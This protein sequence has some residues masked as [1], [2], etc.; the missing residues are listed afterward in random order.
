MKQQAM[1]E[2]KIKEKYQEFKK[3]S[4]SIINLGDSSES[5][6]RAGGD[7]GSFKIDSLINQNRQPELYFRV[8][9]EKSEVYDIITL[10]MGR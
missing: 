8:V 3:N 9:K 1:I 10:V 7:Q 2:A 4:M 6:F 5:N